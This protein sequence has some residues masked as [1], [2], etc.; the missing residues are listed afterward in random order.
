MTTYTGAYG[1]GTYGT[2]SW[3]GLPLELELSLMAYAVGDRILRVE[4]SVEPRHVSTTGPGD[5]LNPRMWRIYN[6]A[7]AKG[8][9]I[10]TVKQISETVYELLTLESF[11]KHQQTL[12]VQV[13]TLISY[14]GSPLPT[15]YA[16]F[17]GCY[18]N[19]A[20][21]QD[22]KT[23]A[24]GFYIQDLTNVPV[25]PL[26]IE[27][28]GELA[29]NIVGGTLQIDSGG[30]YTTQYGTS[31]LKKLILRRLIAKPGDFFHIPNY[32]L[33][34]R[35]KETLPQVE[36]KKLAK[37]IEDAVRLEPEVADVKANLSYSAAASALI[38]QLK[39]LEKSTGKVMPL[40]VS[41]TPNAV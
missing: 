1:T 36:L 7:T 34:L 18:L 31:L 22:A 39:V 6:P 11:P 21:T 9:T 32:G 26:A 28:G 41:L 38:I 3:G 37:A 12:R 35:E 5:A 17:N 10:L 40:T 30:D 20:N 16:D 24:Y 33:G 19:A 8:W 27:I 4:M 2:G 15:A 25:P 29:G 13:T 14:L 23:A